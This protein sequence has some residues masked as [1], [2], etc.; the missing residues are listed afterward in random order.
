MITMV[1]FSCAMFDDR[2]GGVLV[3]I[4]NAPVIIGLRVLVL[5]LTCFVC[6][7]IFLFLV[8]HLSFPRPAWDKWV[9]M[10]VF[11]INYQ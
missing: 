8:L 7:F 10:L 5:S 2:L 11:F 9:A 4:A 3:V 6:I 1:P